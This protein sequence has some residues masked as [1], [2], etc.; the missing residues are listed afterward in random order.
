MPFQRESGTNIIKLCI[1]NSWIY[2]ITMSKK[3]VHP[4]EELSPSPAETLFEPYSSIIP[5]KSK[6]PILV[7]H[8]KISDHFPDFITCTPIQTKD[9]PAMFY[10]SKAKNE[11]LRFFGFSG[12]KVDTI[13]DD[14]HIKKL[15]NDGISV[16]WIA[17]PNVRRKTNFM[18]AYIDLAKNIHQ[19]DAVAD[20]LQEGTPIILGG[21]STGGQLIF[22]MIRDDHSFGHLK[23]NF[24]GARTVISIY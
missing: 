24:N 22:H 8:D 15:N 12:F 4:L 6:P 5:D 17:L 3:N 23:D 20:F 16:G 2:F 21:H 9:G 1:Y 18:P 19:I 11:Q 7:P 14:S 10:S 13:L